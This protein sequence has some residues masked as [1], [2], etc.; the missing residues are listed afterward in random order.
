VREQQIHHL[1]PRRVAGRVQAQ[2]LETL[3]LPDQIGR[4]TAEEIE[5]A[6]ERGAIQWV[7][8]VLD[9]VA[10]DAAL[11]QNVDCAARFPSPG[12]VVDRDLSHGSY[13]ASGG[14]P[15]NRAKADP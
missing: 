9:D 11:A 8:Q 15:C 4:G 2:F 7:L 1:R 12:V 14:D 3:V 13:L 5:E 6:L 10:R